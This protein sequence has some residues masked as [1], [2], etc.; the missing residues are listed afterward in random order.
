MMKRLSTVTALGIFLASQGLVHGFT[1]E[2][3][4]SSTPPPAV[5]SPLTTEMLS[6]WIDDFTTESALP[7]QSYYAQGEIAA[8]KDLAYFLGQNPLWMTSFSSKVLTEQTMLTME[9]SVAVFSLYG[10]DPTSDDSQYWQGYEDT[11]QKTLNAM[12]NWPNTG[13]VVPGTSNPEYLVPTSSVLV[14]ISTTASTSKP[15]LV[16]KPRGQRN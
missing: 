15:R 10:A 3:S 6:E 2:G 9:Q 5:S 7:G 14:P 12:N 13:G 1:Q 11:I 8:T 4:T 16:Q